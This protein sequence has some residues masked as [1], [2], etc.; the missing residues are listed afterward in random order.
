MTQRI[1]IAAF[2]LLWMG[3]ARA[4]SAGTTIFEFLKT[5]YSARG[6]AMAN[7]FVAISGDPT[8]MFANPAAL[9]GIPH[10][11]WSISYVDHLVDLQGGQL[12]YNMKRSET[13]SIGVGLVYFNYGDFDE[14]NEFGETTGR[15]FNAAEFA[16]AANYAQRLG[17]NFNYGV[18]LKFIY[19]SL[20]DFSASGFAVDAGLMYIAPFADDLQFGFSIANLGFLTDKYTDVSEKM[21]LYVRLGF[22][23]RLAHLP[24]LFSASLNDV[25]LKTAEAADFIKRFSVGGEF[26]ISEIVKLRLGYDNGVNQSVKPVAGRSFGGLSAG[27]GINWKKIRLDYAFSNYGDL[28]A[29]NRIG[30]L[31][32]F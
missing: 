28:G 3:N 17:E 5:Q 4:Q 31:G 25:T 13:N 16:L 9:S 20:D 21:P 18:N 26:D 10:S 30:V 27:L 8:A 15:S 1:L 2:L 19:S 29:Q 23:K 24:L 6:A 12:S 7:N 11:Q 14:T 22:S 32:S